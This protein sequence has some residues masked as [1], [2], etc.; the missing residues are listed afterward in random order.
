MSGTAGPAPLA[1]I[2]GASKGIGL[3]LAKQFAEHGHDLVVV[4]SSDRIHAVVPELA[5]YGVS[6]EPIQADLRTRDGVL[7]VWRTVS[8][9]VVDVLALNAGVGIGGDFGETS[10]EDELDVI[11]LN[12][13]SVV[14]LAKLALPRMRERGAGRVLI[15][16]S[17]ASLMPAPFLAVYG[18]SKAFVQSFAEAIREEVREDGVTVTTLLPGPT[19]TDFFRRADMLDTKAAQDDETDD[20]ALVARQAYEAVMDGDHRVLAGSFKHRAQTAIAEH[21][22]EPARAK[23]HRTLSEPGSADD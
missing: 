5:G 3:E 1:V 4:G 2:T 21:L 12:V 8:T 7:E 9:R 16:S 23:M 20:P 15:T 18:A 11:A 22:P 14:H 10:L 19:D 17:E 13:V 6:V